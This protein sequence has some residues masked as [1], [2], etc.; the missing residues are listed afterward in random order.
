MPSSLRNKPVNW[1]EGRILD[2]DGII[3][4]YNQPA[5]LWTGQKLVTVAGDSNGILW[6]RSWKSHNPSPDPRVVFDKGKPNDHASPIICMTKGK[7][8][9]FLSS[10]HGTPL[11][12]W[13]GDDRNANLPWGTRPTS[14][15]RSVPISGGHFVV[16]RGH[17]LSGP[18][19]RHGLLIGA[20]FDS[21][22]NSEPPHT[23]IDWGEGYIVYAGPLRI[24]D[25]IIAIAWTMVDADGEQMPGVWLAQSQDMGRTW[26]DASGNP[27]GSVIDSSLEPVW[28]DPEGR[29]PRIVDLQSSKDGWRIAVTSPRGKGE[30]TEAFLVQTTSKEVKAERITMVVSAYYPVGLCLD[31]HDADIVYATISKKPTNELVRM[32][33]KAGKWVVEKSL[34]HNPEVWIANPQPIEGPVGGPV[35]IWSEATRYERFDDFRA[36]LYVWPAP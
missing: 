26:L 25:G 1:S 20:A 13:S 11:R 16:T 23:I 21:S 24:R 17:P 12:M 7:A 27:I 4:W 22:G 3:L 8:D 34:A 9:F 30:N 29:S 32:R 31:V 28:E 36:S 35:V 10:W 5:S 18:G 14:Y 2:E 33:R 19:S 6:R 15:P